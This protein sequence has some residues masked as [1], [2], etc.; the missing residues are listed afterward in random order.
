MKN[1][2]WIAEPLWIASCT[3]DGDG[4][5]ITCYSYDDPEH[6]LGKLKII[7]ASLPKLAQAL[8]ATKDPRGALCYAAP[9]AFDGAYQID[10]AVCAWCQDV[11][12]EA[13]MRTSIVRGEVTPYHAGICYDAAKAEPLALEVF[14][15]V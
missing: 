14:A 12:L 13:G 9:S 3:F 5:I 1:P 2:D 10:R 4:A 8:R 15:D 11:G 6:E 7:D